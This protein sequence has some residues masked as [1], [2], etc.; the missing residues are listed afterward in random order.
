METEFQLPL[1]KK[2]FSRSAT[3]QLYLWGGGGGF[4]LAT[5]A[6]SP[7]LL[8]LVLQSHR[9][10]CCCCRLMARETDIIFYVK[11]QNVSTILSDLHAKK[12]RTHKLG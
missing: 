8:A 2:S 3:K 4:A 5:V 12:T 1:T 10:Q 11:N 6:S 9:R 7:G